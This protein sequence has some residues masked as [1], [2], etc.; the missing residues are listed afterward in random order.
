M[1][2]HEGDVS[3]INLIVENWGN[4]PALNVR[5]KVNQPVI[6]EGVTGLGEV[7][8]FKKGLSQLGPHQRI[9]LFLAGSVGNLDALKKAPI[10]I[11]AEYRDEGGDEWTQRFTLDFAELEGLTRAGEPPLFTIAKAAEGVR[12]DLAKLLLG[13]HHVRVVNY[14]L[15]DLQR[16]G[17]ITSLHLKLSQLDSAGWADLEKFVEERLKLREP[18]EPNSTS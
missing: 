8:L 14:S 15:E 16:E 5:F 12:S 2:P 4:G 17:K 13:S 11:R 7:G 1:I 9:E 18:N 6:R 3:I 10:E